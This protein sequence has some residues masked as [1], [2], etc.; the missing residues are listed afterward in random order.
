LELK[1]QTAHSLIEARNLE[2][3]KA[4]HLVSQANLVQEAEKAMIAGL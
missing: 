1:L 4:E 3:K 2:L